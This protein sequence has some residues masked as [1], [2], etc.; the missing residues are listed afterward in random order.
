V[1]KRKRYDAIMINVSHPM[2]EQSYFSEWLNM[3]E[4]LPP[5]M[6][7]AVFWNG[8]ILPLI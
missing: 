1:H 7:H 8:N 2:S 5:A 3:W 4:R 6:M